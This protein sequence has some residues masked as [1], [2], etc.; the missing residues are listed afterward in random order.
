MNTAFGNAKYI[1]AGR[2]AWEFTEYD[3]VPLFRREIVLDEPIQTAELLVQSPGFG[4]F[5]ING[6]NV[7]ISVERV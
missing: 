3:P 6:E 4:T 1:R 5:Y 7:T 2:D